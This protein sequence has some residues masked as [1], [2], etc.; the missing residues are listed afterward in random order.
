M[1]SL[2]PSFRSLRCLW[3]L[4]RLWS[5][6]CLCL[7]CFGSGWLNVL[8]S[9]CYW[10]ICNHLSR[11]LCLSL[12][13]S[14]SPRSPVSRCSLCNKLTIASVTS[15]CCVIII[16]KHTSI[17]IYTSLCFRSC[18]SFLSSLGHC[19]VLVITRTPWS[20]SN[21]AIGSLKPH[22]TCMLHQVPAHITLG[23]KVIMTI[24]HY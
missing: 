10:Y 15:W 22:T 14:V 20:H 23:N 2:T 17:A 8:P 7:P 6:R 1:K 4:R 24:K 13:P 3:S 12:S 21:S 9:C 16:V 19:T 18:P 11:C 5:L